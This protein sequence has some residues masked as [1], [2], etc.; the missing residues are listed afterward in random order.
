MNVVSWRDIW[1]NL[2]EIETDLHERFGVD[3]SSGILARRTGRWLRVRIEALLM[4]ADSRLTRALR[5]REG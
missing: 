5:P 3:M 2:D 4:E 1:S